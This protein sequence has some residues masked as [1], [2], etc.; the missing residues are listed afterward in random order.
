MPIINKRIKNIIIKKKKKREREN[1]LLGFS[2]GWLVGWFWMT[3]WL[4]SDKQSVE[5]SGQRDQ[6]G[7]EEK[8]TGQVGAGADA[9]S[10]TRPAAGARP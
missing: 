8:L 5:Q 4:I 10:W 9:T 1:V 2:L 6:D 3:D 7:D